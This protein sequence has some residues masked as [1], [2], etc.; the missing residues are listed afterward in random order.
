[1]YIVTETNQFPVVPLRPHDYCKHHLI[2]PKF[3]ILILLIQCPKRFN[4]S[5]EN[6]VVHSDYLFF[7]FISGRFGNL[8]IL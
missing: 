5:F 8:P 2:G 3:D 4:L 6:L 7:I 1:M